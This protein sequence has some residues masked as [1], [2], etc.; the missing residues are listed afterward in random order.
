MFTTEVSLKHYRKEVLDLI[1]CDDLEVD[2][3][4][5]DFFHKFN[6]AQ[7]DVTSIFS[8]QGHPD[9]GYIAFVCN[10]N[11]KQAI[12]EAFDNYFHRA[13]KMMGDYAY[14]STLNIEYFENFKDEP[15]KCLVWRF[16]PFND[17]EEGIT[18]QKYDISY[19]LDA[20]RKAFDMN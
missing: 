10:D 3:L 14:Q 6:T 8:C 17:T 1:E 2:P 9:G 11:G 5:G 12:E 19:I 20:L 7:Q 15:D 18:L 4:F 13:L 16:I